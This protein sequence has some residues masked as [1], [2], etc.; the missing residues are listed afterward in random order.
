MIKFND[1]NVYTIGGDHKK[2][3]KI[4]TNAPKSM[5]NGIYDFFNTIRKV[6]PFVSSELFTNICPP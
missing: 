1:P 3:N 5:V 4:Y 6:V 2:E